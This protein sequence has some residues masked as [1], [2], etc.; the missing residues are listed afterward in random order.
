MFRHV[1]SP[2]RSHVSKLH[3]QLVTGMGH[4]RRTAD[5]VLK[6][7]VHCPLLHLQYFRPIVLVSLRLGSRPAEVA[8][9]LQRLRVTVIIKVQGWRL[10][11]LQLVRCSSSGM[12]SAVKSPASLHVKTPFKS[13][14]HANL[15]IL[16]TIGCSSLLPRQDRHV[17][18]VFLCLQAATADQNC[19]RIS[20]MCGN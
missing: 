11:Q 5:A 10:D 14:F 1:R 18:Q 4:G 9:V 15:T 6:I 13:A 16:G 17:I 8:R 2:C 3:P 12:A 7:V 20:V 19:C